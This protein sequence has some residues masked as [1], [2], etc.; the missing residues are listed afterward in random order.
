MEVPVSALT[1]FGAGARFLTYT[2]EERIRIGSFCS[3][4]QDATIFTGGGHS[5]DAVSTFPFEARFFG[6]PNPT[7]SSR[8]TRDTEIG[9]DVWVGDRA[10]ICGGVRVGHGAVIGT[11]AVVF[12]DVPPYAIVAGNPAQILRYLRAVAE[13]RG[14]LSWHP[15]FAYAFHADRV[16]DEECGGLELGSLRGLVNCSEPATVESQ[17]RFL[18]RFAR[19]GL[20]PG[21]FLGCYAMAETTFALTHGRSSDPG[22]L[23]ALAGRDRPAPSVGRPLPGVEIEIVGD[24]GA[25]VAERHLGQIRVRSPF[26]FDGYYGN[27]EATRAA[28]RDGWY[29]TGDLGYRVGD[30]LFVSGRRTDLIIIGGVN[31]WPQDLEEIAGSVPGVRPGRAVAFAQFDDALQTE[32]AVILAE[33]DAAPAERRQLQVKIR[34]KIMGAQ[35]IANFEVHLVPPGS[36]V[37][38]SAGKLARG[39]NRDRWSSALLV[40]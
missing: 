12:A 27:V 22:Y 19:C 3:F 26:D 31:V 38:S 1:F 23:D 7:R 36:L 15:N 13:H 25:P 4:A 20:D 39:E 8:T 29:H 2:A 18:G 14:T 17:E 10:T 30:E 21:V 5:V 35:A 32:K 24:D 28:R 9:N 11:G 37:K 34:Q 33:T 40:A 6:A 16:R